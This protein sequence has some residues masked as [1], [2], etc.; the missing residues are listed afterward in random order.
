MSN[1]R[2]KRVTLRAAAARDFAL[3]SKLRND[4]EVQASLLALARPNSPRRVRAWL[5]RRAAADDGAF[6]VIADTG[7]DRPLGFIQAGGIDALHRRAEVGICLDEGARG[8]GLGKEAMAL[9]EDYLAGVFRVRKLW[10]RVDA[11]N[12][13]A[14]ALYRGAGFRAV[15]TLKQHHYARGRYRDVVLMEKMLRKGGR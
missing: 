4:L 12:L 9:L 1:R 10:L 11:A 6:F 15:G 2:A 13:P 3:L 8:R 14:I 5:E 7:D